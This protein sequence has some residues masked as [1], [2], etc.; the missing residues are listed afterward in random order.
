VGSEEL[1]PPN[2]AGAPLA[3]RNLKDFANVGMDLI[4][5]WSAA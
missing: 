4:N 1:E 5:P 2:S 3:T